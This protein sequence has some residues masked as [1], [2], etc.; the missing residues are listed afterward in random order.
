[1]SKKRDTFRRINNIKVQIENQE[2]VFNK[3]KSIEQ[4]KKIENEKDRSLNLF[5]FKSEQRINDYKNCIKTL[6]DKVDKNIENSKKYLLNNSKLTPLNSSKM[7]EAL[8]RSINIENKKLNK[9][10]RF[11]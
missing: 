2:N 6:E 11:I 9:N 1:M 8:N 5:D 10:E 4:S 7:L 3:R